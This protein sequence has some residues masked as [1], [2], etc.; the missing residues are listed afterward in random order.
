MNTALSVGS[1]TGRPAGGTANRAV[2]RIPVS[3][4]ADRTPR[5]EAP[6]FCVQVCRLRL[7]VRTQSGKSAHGFETAS[8]GMVW[9]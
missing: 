5:T 1:N 9:S 2:C 4:A 7:H 8:P 3:N 6:G